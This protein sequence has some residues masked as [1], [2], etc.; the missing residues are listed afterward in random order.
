MCL[1][2][3]FGWGPNLSFFGLGPWAIIHGI[4]QKW[5]NYLIFQIWTSVVPFERSV[6]KLLENHNIV[7]IES[8][9]FKLWWLKESPIH[10]VHCTCT[11]TYLFGDFPWTKWGILIDTSCVQVSSGTFT[12]VEESV[13]AAN[14]IVSYYPEFA[15]FGEFVRTSE[16]PNNYTRTFDCY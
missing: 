6:S 5:G 4:G 15:G 11:C 16:F 12:A 10:G 8:T 1:N 2:P 13:A 7:E 3:K 9:E 14:A